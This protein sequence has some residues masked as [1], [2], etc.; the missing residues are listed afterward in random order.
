MMIIKIQHYN[1]IMQGI[2]KPT[3]SSSFRKSFTHSTAKDY[4][5]S[6]QYTILIE[7][8]TVIDLGSL[9]ICF[10]PCHCHSPQLPMDKR[11]MLGSQ[12][13]SL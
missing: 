4:D 8:K 2:L 7:V 5:Y 13:V 6:A 3:R 11:H 1:T 10:Q 12:L 9:N